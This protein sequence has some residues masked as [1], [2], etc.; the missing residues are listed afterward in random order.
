M[1]H[2]HTLALTTNMQ[3]AQQKCMPVL[4]VLRLQ[5]KQMTL[6]FSYHTVQAWLRCMKSIHLSLS[7]MLVCPG[8]FPCA[9][10]VL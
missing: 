5:K 1:R 7:H 2:V 3:C 10:H 4:L 6:Q 9:K 8:L